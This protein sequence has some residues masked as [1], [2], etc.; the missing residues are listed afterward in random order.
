MDGYWGTQTDF[1][2]ETIRQRIV[3]GVVMP[4]FRDSDD[5]TPKKARTT[6]PQQTQAAVRDF[7]GSVGTHLTRL[8]LPYVHKLAWDKTRRVRRYACHEK[9]H[10]SLGRVLAKILETYGE[11]G[12]EELGLNLFG[13]CF[14][15]RKKKGG[16]T[17]SM[18]S[19]GIAV[20]YHPEENRFRWGW[21]R[22]VFARPEYDEWW[23][24]WEAEG[25]TSLGRTR[26]FDWMHIQAAHL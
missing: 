6:W 20:D 26:N 1:A 7:Y 5:R 9:V 18:H 4:N 17:W 8:E 16:S 12:I 15:K 3:N 19:W 14:N 21:D 23:A 22:A 13:G 11:E 24:I 25:W 2:V 10:D